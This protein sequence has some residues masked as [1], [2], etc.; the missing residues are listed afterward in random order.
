MAAC[1]PE[2]LTLTQ[3]FQEPGKAFKLFTTWPPGLGHV[4]V[5]L[6]AGL[7]RESKQGRMYSVTVWLQQ[8]TH[9]TLRMGYYCLPP[10]AE[11]SPEFMNF[12]RVWCESGVWARHDLQVKV[13]NFPL[14]PHSFSYYC[15][16]YCS[17][18]NCDL[19]PSAVT[20]A[21]K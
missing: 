11:Q 12:F 7:G 6:H 17:D 5:Q 20:G 21:T 8:T 13:D 15:W 4:D 18:M 9:L 1:K 3:H 16:L 14:P 19:I 2:H 10:Q